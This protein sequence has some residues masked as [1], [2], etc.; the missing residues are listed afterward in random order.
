MDTGYLK[1]VALYFL[2]VLG[3]LALIFY[4]IYHLM[5]GFTTDISTVTAELTTKQNVVSGDGYIFR[6]EKYVTASYG[7]TVDY[8]VH[9]GEK[10]SVE[11]PL[12]EVFADESGLSIRS[13]LSSIE[14]KLSVIEGSRVNSA[15]TSPDTTVID[16]QI[17]DDYRLILSKIAEGKFSHAMRTS[18]N[19]LIEMSK[20][21]TVTG[22]SD[23]DTLE[24][25]L[26]SR[27][28][29][30][31]SQ[32]TGHSETVLS[33]ESGYFFTGID[34]YENIFTVSALDNLTV[35]SFYSLI[36]KNPESKSGAGSPIGKLTKTYRWYIAL[37]MTKS[38][39]LGFSAGNEYT[40]VFSYNY[41]AE[42]TVK[43][44]KVLTEVTDDRAVVVFSCGTMPDSFS[45]LRSQTVSIV[46]AEESGLRVPKSAVRI[47]DG[48]KGIYTL[49]GSTVKF[50]RIDILLETD[51]YYIVST[52]DPT[53]PVIVPRSDDET[54]EDEVFDPASAPYIK[55]YDQ[56]IVSGKDL[57]DG[58]VFY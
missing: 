39:A 30:L 23:F 24:A 46:T 21:Q 44:E 38:E 17:T 27:K 33:S 7:G 9:D 18:E 41:D 2:S 26:S 5:D 22:N 36:E 31:T 25:N 48:V 15:L 51:G 55:L 32:L 12:A 19:L 29:T 54:E 11:Q 6:D 13:E 20:R 34:G 35:N 37:P 40:A 56:I 16:R 43:V 8:I 47:I 49:Y 45:Y 14:K 10:V 1:K 4:V 52:E 58:M 3:A 57:E 53:P 28:R 42:L 50:K